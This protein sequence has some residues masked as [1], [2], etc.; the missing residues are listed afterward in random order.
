MLSRYQ[1]G[2][3]D[4][5]TARR[6][7]E[8]L[9]SC[10]ACEERFRV[11]GKLG[12]FL[13]IGLGRPKNT[14]CPTSE[15]IA[16]YLAGH[17]SAEHRE[18]I[19]NHLAGCE[20]CLHEVAVFSDDAFERLTPSS[21]VPTRRALAAFAQLNQ[22]PVPPSRWRR[23]RTFAWRTA[24]RAAAAVVLVAV[25]VPITTRHA[26]KETPSN[27][28]ATDLANAPEPEVV[29]STDVAVVEPVLLAELPEEGQIL[30]SDNPA[31]SHFARQMRLILQQVNETAEGPTVQRVELLQED[32]LNSGLVNSVEELSAETRDPANRKFLVN[33]K[34]VLLKI[35][36][37]DKANAS[38]DLLVL[39]NELR[40]MN[41]TETA[42]LIEL[43]GGGL[44]WLMTASL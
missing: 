40:Q 9:L 2:A 17:V 19:E 10:P 25:L 4:E 38:N 37:M 11:L 26:P 18:R 33:C 30:A 3:L 16:A 41:L 20:R 35:V 34:Y 21:P 24:L 7:A 13:R 27:T 14:P 43:E 15:E 8:H 44:L 42:R 29:E 5:Q 39:V 28:T 32:V 36:R 31:L 23:A 12:L 22:K 1:D 6:V